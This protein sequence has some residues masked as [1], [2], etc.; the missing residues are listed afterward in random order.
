MKV[1]RNVCSPIEIG[2]FSFNIDSVEGIESEP[3]GESESA[4]V[5]PLRQRRQNNGLNKQT[6]NINIHS[7]Q[8]KTVFNDRIE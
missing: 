3:S 7:K 1:N 5:R 2:F 4:L 6:R 8:F